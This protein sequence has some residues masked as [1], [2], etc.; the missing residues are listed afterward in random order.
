[1]QK[2]QISE[3]VSPTILI[4]Y[5]I[6][7][8]NE[9]IPTLKK[10]LQEGWVDLFKELWEK[11]KMQVTCILCF[12]YN[13]FYFF[14][15]HFGHIQPIVSKCFHSYM[16]KTLSNCKEPRNLEYS[17]KCNPESLNIMGPNLN[18]HLVDSNNQMDKQWKSLS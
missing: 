18:S 17:K 9:T 1:M 5:N 12:P 2:D 8:M 14:R 11:E 6:L 16:F 13:V 4:L 15:N 7:H 3:Q 10:P